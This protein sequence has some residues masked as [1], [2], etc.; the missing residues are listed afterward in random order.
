MAMPVIVPVGEKTAKA[1]RE[2]LLQ[3]IPKLRIG[4][5]TD[6]ARSSFLVLTGRST[7]R[8]GTQGGKKSVVAP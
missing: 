2:R 8:G 4:G 5:F 6:S 1:V 3:E 7:K